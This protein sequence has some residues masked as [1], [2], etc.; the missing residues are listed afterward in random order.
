M[1]NL[2]SLLQIIALYF[3]N[4]IQCKIISASSD[5]NGFYVVLYNFP[6]ILIDFRRN[7]HSYVRCQS[8]RRRSQPHH[9][10]CCHKMGSQTSFGRR[11]PKSRWQRGRRLTTKRVPFSSLSWLAC[12]QN[13]VQ[14]DS[15]SQA[16]HVELCVIRPV[17]IW[18]ERHN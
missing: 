9:Q 8:T 16:L 7:D 15:F 14:R 12:N 17:R 5:H 18:G 1:A 6:S 3:Q 11:R 10:N 4:K 2:K 13:E